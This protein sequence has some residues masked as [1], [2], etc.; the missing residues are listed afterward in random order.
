MHRLKSALAV[1]ACLVFILDVLA[2]YTHMAVGRTNMVGT[3]IERRAVII[4]IIQS[5]QF[6]CF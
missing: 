6:D 1:L 2:M 4:T 5:K 3:I